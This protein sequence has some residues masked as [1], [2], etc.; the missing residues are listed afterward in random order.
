MNIVITG[1]TSFI[2]LA[3]LQELADRHQLMVVVRPDSENKGLLPR[4]EHIHMIQKDLADIGTLEELPTGTVDVWIHMGW[5]GSG[6][7]NRKNQELQQSN[8]GMVLDA[9]RT[10]SR[11]GCRR[12][13]FSGSQAEYG[14]HQEK[15]TEETRCHPVS[16]YGKAKLETGNQAKTLC[17]SLNIEYIHTRIFS[18]YGPGDHP[19]TLVNT[20]LDTFLADQTMVM[21]DCTQWWNFLYIEDMAKAMA[22]LVEKEQ[23]PEGI[24][25]I[26]GDDTRILREFVTEMHELCGGRG[27]CSYGELPVNAEGAANLNPD[28]TKI[29]QATGWKPEIS[30]AEGIKRIIQAKKA[31]S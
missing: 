5:N 27:S 26:A 2:G 30:F 25:N 16:E 24:Y 19:W 11:F 3:L 20:C 4:H 1:A 14:I 6:S 22:A 13:I 31:M 29:K 10:A 7:R 8:I 15:I 9:V 23:L 28:I 17:K 21:G 18:V 12:F